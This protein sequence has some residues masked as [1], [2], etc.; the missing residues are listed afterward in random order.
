MNN[1][2]PSKLILALFIKSIIYFALPLYLNLLY[3]SK[4]YSAL[5]DPQIILA[6]LVS[7]LMNHHLCSWPSWEVSYLLI[8]HW[9]FQSFNHRI[10]T[11]Q[12]FLYLEFQICTSNHRILV[13]SRELLF[14]G[15]YICWA[16][17]ILFEGC[18]I[19]F[20]GFLGQI[21]VFISVDVWCWGSWCFYDW[22]SMS[23]WQYL[24]L[25]P[26]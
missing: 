5:I 19:G 13:L 10:S 17:I 24:T 18:F 26:Q 22:S 15:I 7:K 6:K 12:A 21:L 3:F 23:L 2:I 4:V 25:T 16:T 20:L 8:F 14:V 1:Q 11:H 9:A